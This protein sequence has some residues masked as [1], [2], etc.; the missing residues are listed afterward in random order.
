MRMNERK[1]SELLKGYSRLKP[2]V[3][4]ENAP[5]PEITVSSVAYGKRMAETEGFEPSIPFWG[6]LI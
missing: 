1:A 3:S 4:P 5:I 2:G 6:M